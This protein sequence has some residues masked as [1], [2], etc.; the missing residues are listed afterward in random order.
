MNLQVKLR[1][2]GHDIP[3]IFLTGHGDVPTAVRA[4]KQGAVDFIEKPFN[5][6]VLLDA[7][8]RAL[9]KDAANRER[10]DWRDLSRKLMGRSRRSKRKS[11]IWSWQ[12][13]PTRS[14]PTNVRARDS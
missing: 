8:Y 6:Q 7:I 2:M 3:V 13:M 9:E 1:E 4:M 5:A 10:R 11:L 12:A 14:L